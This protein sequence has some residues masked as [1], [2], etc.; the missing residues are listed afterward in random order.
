MNDAVRFIYGLNRRTH[1]TPY[2][3]KLHL[4]P[5]KFRI[6]F[7]LCTLAYNIVDETAPKYLLDIFSCYQ[8][9]SNMALRVGSGRDDRMLMYSAG[10]LPYK[11]IF[12]RLLNAWNDLPYDLRNAETAFN[13]K[14]KLKTY[15]FSKA[16]ENYEEQ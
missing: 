6:L 14:K 7:K 8:P 10:N 12:Q 1:I 15:Y 11:C 3:Y 2:L 16:Y 9:T 5:V 4:L 13:F